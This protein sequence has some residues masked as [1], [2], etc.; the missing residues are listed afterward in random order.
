MSR[1]LFILFL[2]LFLLSSTLNAAKVPIRFGKVSMAE[3]QQSVCPIDSSASAV[4]LCNFGYFR[5][6]DF[7]FTQIKRIKILKKEG[8]RHADIITHGGDD[9]NIK[10]VTLNLVDGKTEKTKLR[11][12]SIFK[13]N[14]TDNNYR[15][16]IAFPDVKVG[17]VI[18]VRIDYSGMP[19]T[20][21]FQEKI[22]VLHSELL[23]EPSMYIDFRKNMFG[24]ESLEKS[25]DNHF[26]AK[27]VPAFKS[28]AFMTSSENYISKLEFDILKISYP[29]YY[30]SFTTDWEALRQ[31]LMEHQYFGQV[32]R[33]GKNYLKDM[34][35]E[36]I[37]EEGEDADDLTKTKA[38]CKAIKQVKWN[39]ES[40]LTSAHNTLS[41]V[42]KDGS[43]NSAELNLMLLHL[44]EELNVDAHPVVMSTRTNGIMNPYFPSLEKLN[45]V[46]VAANIEGQELLM[47]ATAKYLPFGLLPERCINGQGRLLTDEKSSLIPLAPG[48]SEESATIYSLKM[49]S[50]GLLSGQRRFTGKDFAGASFRENYNNHSNQEDFIKSWHDD[51][52]GL[53][54]NKMKIENLNEIEKAIKV[55][56]EITL[57]NQLTTI[58]TL[59]FFNP[60][61]MEQIEENPFKL[62]DRKYPVDFAYTK[63]KSVVISIQLPEN[64]SISEIP[65]SQIIKLPGNA[66]IA[67]IL[68][69]A[70]GNH[71]IVNYQ[72]KINKALFLP[73]EYSHL[74]TF[75]D[76]II[77][78]QKEPVILISQNNPA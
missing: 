11:R 62:K 51:Y 67:K 69:Q 13:E 41:T 30:K 33:R 72:F 55:D 24:F 71:I 57:D 52:A 3:M 77:N 45:Y 15:Y 74:K 43:G 35:E 75:Y 6:R 32:I 70:S 64:I 29:G 7:S 25:T 61:C 23:I 49:D 58:D 10:G 14:V 20:W 68:Y 4:V 36:I 47:D 28:E 54:I 48:G 21:Y 42:F 53:T 19:S 37:A 76:K 60:F 2:P 17:S 9:F 59:H 31:T 39:E 5:G 73:Q 16:R 34:V 78:K 22:P 44:L 26:I 12:E 66:A 8:T 46:I 65:E 27:N 40:T 38:A 18:D 63:S 1:N 56:Y 50:E